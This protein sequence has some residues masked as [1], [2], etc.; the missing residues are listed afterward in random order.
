MLAEFPTGTFHQVAP[1]MLFS[2]TLGEVNEVM[3]P[4]PQQEPLGCFSATIHHASYTDPH[5]FLF[6]TVIAFVFF[7]YATTI[8]SLLIYPNILPLEFSVFQLTPRH[9]VDS[10]CDSI[11]NAVVR[12]SLR[13]AMVRTILLICSTDDLT[14]PP[15]P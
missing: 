6:L 4:V 9:S 2:V 14:D 5:L 13:D 12:C 3:K 1:S 8:L 7:P 10:T 15:R 11:Q